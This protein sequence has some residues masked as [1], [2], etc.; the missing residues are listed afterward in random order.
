MSTDRTIHFHFDF[1][2]P[3]GYLASLRIDD[4]AEKHKRYCEWHPMLLGISVLKIMG[5]PPIAELPLKG[6]YIRNDAARYARRHNVTLGRALGSPQ[7]NPLL[8]SRLV[9]WLKFSQPLLAREVAGALYSAHWEF[10][11][12]ISDMNIAM[13]ILESKGGN[14][15][16]F[17]EVINNGDAAKA[18]R[19]EVDQS[20]GF[21]VFGS[22]T[23]RVG[24]ELFFGVEKLEV[25]DDWL[26]QGGW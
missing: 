17:L 10:D 8:P 9:C 4:L 19:E 2:S 26:S 23:V 22:P 24:E 5:L 13:E 11:R 6:P 20:I 16:E 15:T 25:V 7:I 3:F 1:L 12:D 21:G 18:L 14:K